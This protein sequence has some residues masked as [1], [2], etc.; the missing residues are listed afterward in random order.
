MEAFG[1]WNVILTKAGHVV[2]TVCTSFKGTL[3]LGGVVAML[4][5][6]PSTGDEHE[7]KR[8]FDLIHL[9]KIS[10]SDAILVLN[11]DGYYGDSTRREI[12]WA[13]MQRKDVYWL[14]NAELGVGVLGPSV[15]TL[16]NLFDNSPIRFVPEAAKY[17]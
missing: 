9:D 10:N 7:T 3:E 16:Y 11:V 17:N 13:R 8:R 14:R 4:E 12:E 6:D 1:D 5:N 15:W 2:Y